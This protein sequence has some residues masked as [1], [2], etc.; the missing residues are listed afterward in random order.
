MFIYDKAGNVTELYS[1]DARFTEESRF[2]YEDY[3]KDSISPI[4]KSIS[5]SQSF[6]DQT[7]PLDLKVHATDDTKVKNVK[8]TSR[9]NDSQKEHV[10]TLYL[11]QS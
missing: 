5:L 1:S 8:V 7:Q 4:F 9:H 10:T 3:T 11:L 6:L 2:I